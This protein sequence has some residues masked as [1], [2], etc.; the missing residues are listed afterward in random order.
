MPG[1]YEFHSGHVHW[2]SS[3]RWGSEHSKSLTYFPM[4]IQLIHFKSEYGSLA[5]AKRH[6]DGLAGLAVFFQTIAEYNY[7]LDYFTS[8]LSNITAPGSSVELREPFPLRYFL[9]KNTQDF[10]R[11]YLLITRT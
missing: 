10:F 1:T 2:G 9:P 5:E 11:Y 4:E 6:K 8:V 3:Y 7:K